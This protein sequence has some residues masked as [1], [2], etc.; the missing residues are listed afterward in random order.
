MPKKA[1]RIKRKT[2]TRVCAEVLQRAK[3]INDSDEYTYGVER[4]DL[5]GSY[6]KKNGDYVGDLD[7]MVMVRPKSADLQAEPFCHHLEDERALSPRGGIPSL[8]Y[9]YERVFKKLKSG[10]RT[11]S[12]HD[13]DIENGK[14]G[15]QKQIFS[16][17]LSWNEGCV[18]QVLAH[19]EMTGNVEDGL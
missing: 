2:A 10:S 9:P 6:H 16:A 11:V 17:E 15:L 8:F 19:G 4:I 14:V 12:L 1:Q 3:E 18:S 5:F 7:L 13:F